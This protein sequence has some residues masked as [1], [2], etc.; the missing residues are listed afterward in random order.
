MKQGMYRVKIRAQADKE[1]LQSLI[2][3]LG[4]QLQ[5]YFIQQRV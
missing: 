1:M 3:D 4:F 2:P 5:Q